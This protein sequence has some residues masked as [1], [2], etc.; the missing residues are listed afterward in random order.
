MNEENVTD[1]HNEIAYSHKKN[2]ILSF[3]TTMNF[4]DIVLRGIIQA[5]TLNNN[6]NIR[7]GTGGFTGGAG[8]GEVWIKRYTVSAK[9]REI[10]SR[11]WWY[12]VVTIVSKNLLSLEWILNISST[13]MMCNF[14][15]YKLTCFSQSAHIYVSGTMLFPNTFHI[16]FPLKI[17]V[18]TYLETGVIC[19]SF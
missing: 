19:F 5:P 16:V 11:D 15:E 7:W 3:V 12:S 17:T 9:A 8:I 6:Q 10:N 1:I 13:K 18:P 14:T 4:E 2:G